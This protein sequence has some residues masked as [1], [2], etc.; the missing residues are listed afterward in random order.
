MRLVPRRSRGC[1][2]TQIYW[3]AEGEG[4]THP[5][6]ALNPNP[7]SVQLDELP[8]EGQPQPRALHLLVRRSHLPELLEHRLL[9]FRGNADTGVPDGDLHEPVPWH[10]A[11]FNPPTLGRELD[12]IRQQVQHDLSDLPFIGL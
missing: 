7:A 1:S 6:L 12:R 2:F 5:Q 3:Q 11:D 4:R 8:T 10:S 9:I